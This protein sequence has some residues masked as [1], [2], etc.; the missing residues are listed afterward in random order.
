MRFSAARR[1]A[2]L[3][4]VIF[5]GQP[6]AR[7]EID[8][9]RVEKR[10]AF[11]AEQSGHDVGV[12]PVPASAQES[13]AIDDAVTGQRI[14]LRGE[15]QCPAD[16]ARRAGRAEGARD[17]P[18]GGDASARN[19][20]HHGKDMLEEVRPAGSWRLA[21]FILSGGMK[22]ALGLGHEPMVASSLVVHGDETRWIQCAFFAA[23][24]TGTTPRTSRRRRLRDAAI[25]R[26][27]WKLVYGG[28]HVGLMGALA[29]AALAED[30]EVIGVMPRALLTREIAHPGITRIHLVTSMHRRK[31]LMAS[32]S[33][34]FLTLPGGYGTLEEF[35]ETLTWAQ[36][37]LHTKPCALLDVA[38]FW[39]DLLAMVDTQIREGFA[40]DEHRQLILSGEDPGRASRSHGG[41]RS[42]RI[43]RSRA[44]PP[45]STGRPSIAIS[46]R[47]RLWT[48]TALRSGRVPNEPEVGG[49]AIGYRSLLVLAVLPSC[50]L[51]PTSD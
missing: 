19:V 35:F 42:A 33:D 12:A 17:S 14:L 29:D 37:G 10:H 50:R 3:L 11:V 23:R 30:G 15:A 49:S 32:L 24:E 41:V 18:V 7:G 36:L 27:G 46:S 28:G 40:P 4:E 21:V 16:R 6:E 5:I 8:A 47:N 38:G 25:A 45:A 44:G 34:G 39:D 2:G 1:I 26:R 22:R 51:L 43:D 20:G 31:A 13:V 9:I 48:G